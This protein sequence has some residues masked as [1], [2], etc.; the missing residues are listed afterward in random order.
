[1]KCDTGCTFFY[2]KCVT[3]FSAPVCEFLS[4]WK[5]LFP[6]GGGLP[7]GLYFLMGYQP[8]RESVFSAGTNLSPTLG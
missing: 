5:R 6:V 1:M 7:V 8:G 2:R 4:D 3:T